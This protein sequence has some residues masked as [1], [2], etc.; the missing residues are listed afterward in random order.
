MLKLHKMDI[1]EKKKMNFLGTDNYYSF[2]S[3][4]ELLGFAKIN[5]IE[6]VDIYIFILEEKRGNGFGNELFSHVLEKVKEEGIHSFSISFPLNNVIMRKIV[7]T[8]GGRE[9]SRKE[10]LIKYSIIL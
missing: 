4:E 6:K 5:V 7:E 3:E 2:K 10:N 8:Y 1:E 9:E